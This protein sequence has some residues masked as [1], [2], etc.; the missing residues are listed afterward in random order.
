MRCL[1]LLDS[2]ERAAIEKSIQK[3]FYV[4]PIFIMKNCLERNFS[5]STFYS[6]GRIHM[7]ETEG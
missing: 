4:F 2:A 3:S 7:T 5:N 6:F 1:E